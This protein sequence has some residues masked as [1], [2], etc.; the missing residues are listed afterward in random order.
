MNGK[1]RQGFQVGA[2]GP[3]DQVGKDREEDRH[4]VEDRHCANVTCT[5]VSFTVTCVFLSLSFFVQFRPR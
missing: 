5:H 4:H 3:E 2:Q 1:V